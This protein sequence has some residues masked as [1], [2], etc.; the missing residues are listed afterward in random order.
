MKSLA[1]IGVLIALAAISGPVSAGGSFS[2]NVLDAT[3][4]VIGVGMAACIAD[5]DPQGVERAVRMGEAVQVSVQTARTIKGF[6]S[7]GFPSGHAAGAFAAATTLAQYHPKQ[8]WLY[9]GLAA[10][11]GWTTVRSGSHTLTE[12]IAG[13]GLGVGVAKL[14]IHNDGLLIGKTYRF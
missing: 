10:F 8:K 1:I 3:G 6:T 13:A 5:G 2:S 11:V 12:T 14:S 4:P 9:Y 7:S